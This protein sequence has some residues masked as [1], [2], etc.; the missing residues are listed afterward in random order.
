MSSLGSPYFGPRPSSRR[1]FL[2]AGVGLAG[3]A[4]LAACGSD[5][6]SSSSSATP[7]SAGPATLNF[8]NYPDWIGKDEV[9]EFE[10]ADP[11]MKVKQTAIADGGVA[12][13][14]AQVA[15]NK[16]AFDFALLGL[17]TAARLQAGA[18]L[19][20]FDPSTVPNLKNIPDNF[21][22]MFPWGIPTD[23]G[24]VGLG[25]RADL[26]PAPPA[27][28]KEL[29]DA[30]PDYSGKV[31]FPDY[32]RDVL[33]IALLALG[34]SINSADEGELNNAKDLIIKAKPHLKAFL[35]ADQGGGLADGSA[36]MTVF[37]D[38]SYGSVAGKNANIKWSAPSEGM[39]AYIEGWVPLVGSKYLPQLAKFMD[40]HL[41][42]QVYG[43]FINATFSSYLMSSAEPYIDAK[44]KGDPAL[45]YD[46][47]A[48]LQFEQFT[49]ADGEQIRTKVW[50]E[51]KAA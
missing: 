27:S 11:G 28:W 51:I 37:Y 25:Y 2:A 30:L 21:V 32:D 44:I 23:L 20:K 10:A 18:L 34:Y 47:T 8:L 24:K 4:F 7:A 14:S 1:S 49:S 42:P 38:Y 41:Q 39:P 6:G 29:F 50:E 12:A 13:I 36:V 35:S 5:D 9:A 40:F 17:V 31:I 16:G 22:K 19:S 48:N 26:V 46:A 33:G 15:Q 45:K 3:A 43:D